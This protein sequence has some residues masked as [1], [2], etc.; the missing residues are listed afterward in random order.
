MVRLEAN[1]MLL[2]LQF[3]ILAFSAV[4]QPGPK[5]NPGLCKESLSETKICNL[6]PN[7]QEDENL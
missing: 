3:F 6:H 2:L 1:N 5:I 4:I 7:K